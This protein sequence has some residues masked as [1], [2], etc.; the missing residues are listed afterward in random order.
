MSKILD[1]AEDFE[2]KSREQAGVIESNLKSEFERHEQ[3]IKR[4]LRSNEQRITDDINAQSERLSG[5][6]LKTWIWLPVTVITVLLACWGV[7]WWQG[8]TI[9]QNQQ[10][11]KRQEIALEK[12]NAKIWGVSLYQDNEGNYLV[13]PEGYT[14]QGGWT[15]ND[16]KNELIKLVEK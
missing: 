3:F 10:E 16:G 6:V 15:L 5:L 1:L 13:I 8:M 9:V 7:I 14:V 11:I 2:R 12:L 4:E